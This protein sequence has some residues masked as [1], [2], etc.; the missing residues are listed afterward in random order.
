MTILAAIF[1]GRLL[2]FQQ[3]P[4]HRRRQAEPD[5]AVSGFFRQVIGHLE[6]DQ[7][8][9]QPGFPRPGFIQEFDQFQVGAKGKR[10]VPSLLEPFGELL[11]GGDIS[12]VHVQFALLSEARQG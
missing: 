2:E 1:D 6:V 9:L 3:F 10:V 11:S 5:Q 8:G 12:D 7:I 4:R